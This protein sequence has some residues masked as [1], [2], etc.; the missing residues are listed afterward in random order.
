MHYCWKHYRSPQLYPLL[1]QEYK[2]YKG[3]PATHVAP[4]SRH[5]KPQSLGL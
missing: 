5:H 3:L 4:L 2:G 1:P